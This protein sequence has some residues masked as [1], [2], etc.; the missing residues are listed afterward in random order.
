[1]SDKK[2]VERTPTM[3]S[4]TSKNSDIL[5]TIIIVGLIVLVVSFLYSYSRFAWKKGKENFE[6]LADTGSS[7]K[8]ETGPI[9][10]GYFP[11]SGSK[12]VSNDNASNIWWHYPT[13]VEGSYAQITNNIR[14]PNNPDIGKCTPADF[15]GAL[16]KNRKTNPS[17]YVYPLPPAEESDGARVNYYRVTPNLLPL[18]IKTNENILY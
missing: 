10:T 15:C 3:K 14:Y 11:F 13:F 18:S 4:I 8:D 6:S 9:L 17:N 1:M 12:S 7:I 2:I 16:Y 5:P